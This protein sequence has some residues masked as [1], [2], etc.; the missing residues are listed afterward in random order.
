MEPFA[1][2]LRAIQLKGMGLPM[3]TSDQ[4][5]QQ[6]PG[7]EERPKRAPGKRV[8]TGEAKAAPAEVNPPKRKKKK[9]KNHHPPQS[10]LMGRM[11]VGRPTKY[12]A[13]ICAALLDAASEGYSLEGAAVQCGI[14]WA[15]LR[16]WKND[17]PEFLAV[18]EEARLLA[19]S[20]WEKQARLSASGQL[21]GNARL[22]EFGLR[23]RS[24]HASGWH[25]TR[26]LEV[27]GANGG[28]IQSTQNL[29]VAPMDVSNLNADQREQLRTLLLAAATPPRLIEAV[30]NDAAEDADVTY[31]DET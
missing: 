30:V 26:T 22:I 7:G 21:D 16:S 10:A 15:S 17:I 13:A 14:S 12:S 23:N 2:T 19:A 28:A 1:G 20:W 6:P 29:Q 27:T 5:Q 24:R 4:Q 3:D 9:A 25:D 18:T 31:D 11:P 8:P